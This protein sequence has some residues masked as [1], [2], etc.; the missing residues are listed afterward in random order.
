MVDSW[1]YLSESGR[2]YR[3]VCFGMLR[4]LITVTLVIWPEA[5]G[6]SGLLGTASFLISKKQNGAPITSVITSIKH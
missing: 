4:L 2:P 5:S 3:A 1:I 6:K